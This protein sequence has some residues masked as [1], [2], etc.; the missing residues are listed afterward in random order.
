MKRTLT[1]LILLTIPAF[2]F[3]TVLTKSTAKTFVGDGSLLT[4]IST[5]TFKIGD[6]YSGGKV[7]WV[8]STGTQVLIATGM[9]V[10]AAWGGGGLLN[11]S[12]DGVY[13]GKTNTFTI[14][15]EYPTT[16]TGASTC[17]DLSYLG[18]NNGY[19]NDWYLPSKAELLLLYAQRALFPG[20]ANNYYQSST[21]YDA[22]DAWVVNFADGTETHVP[23]FNGVYI[24]CIRAGP[25]T[26]ISNFPTNAQ[27]VTNGA[28][29]TST[30]TFSGAN[31][32]TSSVTIGGNLY[33]TTVCPANYRL[34]GD[35]LGVL[36][37]QPPAASAGLTFM[38]GGAS[39]DIAGYLQMVDVSSFTPAARSTSTVA[40]VTLNQ[41]ISSAATNVGYPNTTYIPAG[42]WLDHLHA[43]AGA[44]NR[45]KLTMEVYTRTATGVETDLCASEQSS[46][47]PNTETELDMYA[48]CASTAIEATT[49]IIRK[50]KATTVTGAATSI[51]IYG[52]GFGTNATN[53]RLEL[54]STAFSANTYLPKTGGTMTGA[55]AVTGASSYITGQSS[56][57]TTGNFYGHGA[58]LTGII[59]STATG[60]Y[61]LSISGN[62]ATVTTNA[63]LTGNVTS[64][65]NTTTLVSVPASAVDLSTVTS[66]LGGKQ[67]TGNY[68]TALTGN[69]TASGPGSVV[70]TIVSIPQA[71]VNLS[72]VTTRIAALESKT[73]TAAYLGDTQTFTGTN[74]FAAVT[75]SSMTLL[76]T[77]ANDLQI[78]AAL[79]SIATLSLYNDTL[80]GL[81]IHSHNGAGA[82]YKGVDF[83]GEKAETLRFMGNGSYSFATTDSGD[84][85]HTMMVLGTTSVDL[86]NPDPGLNSGIGLRVG[87]GAIF[88]S[89]VTASS[90]SGA[91]ILFLHQ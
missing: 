41:Y 32:F 59:Q 8:D 55:L 69:V 58:T 66:A 11:A 2:S 22:S 36:T 25:A 82:G 35:G 18:G 26:S 44:G 53:A 31:T 51:S 13:A 89:S 7:F 52:S 39:P 42:T 62:A 28:Y 72:T 3:A 70:A 65:G 20:Y 60:S 73:S 91:G 14:N 84:A 43:V 48:V 10:F 40:S 37:C 57:T 24:K 81:S 83:A 1:L 68:I 4:G 45:I 77:G 5:H 61:P 90:F 33:P 78:H 19:F 75:A 86:N 64:V 50:L 23:K 71:A 80:L 67:A 16:T 87:S 46:F 49:R 12:L 85:A 63:N 88:S 17:R 38:I 21:E 47:I 34:V 74:Y 30:Q 79:N 76:S 27:T 9:N 15:T 29:I 56:I 6:S 54:P